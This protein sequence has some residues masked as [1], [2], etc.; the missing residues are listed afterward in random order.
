MSSQLQIV[1]L[2]NHYFVPSGNG[3]D[4]GVPSTAVSVVT[5]LRPGARLICPPPI[6]F[7]HLV[8]EMVGIV[9]QKFMKK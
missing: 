7:L 8:R 3:F 1:F 2:G 5:I 9:K 6:N 4:G